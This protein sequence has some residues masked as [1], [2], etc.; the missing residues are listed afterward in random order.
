M[1]VD[2]FPELDRMLAG[3]P[4][5][6]VFGHLGYV[7][8]DK[9]TQTPGF[10]ALIR[11][12]RDGRAWAKLTGPYR[13]SQLPPSYGDTDRFAAALLEAAPDRLVWGTDWPH[14]KVSWD[15]AMPNDGDLADLLGRW[16]GDADLRR[17]VLVDNPVRLYGFDPGH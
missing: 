2:E 14:V 3:M 6:F 11:L 9:G 1:H 13:I 16:I 15:H 7:R 5:E 12:L 17:K 10:E 4:V 8:T